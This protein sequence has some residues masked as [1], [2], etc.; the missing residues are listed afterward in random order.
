MSLNCGISAGLGVDC[1]DL[2]KPGGVAKRLWLFNIDDLRVRL[3]TS[4]ASYITDLEFTGYRGLYE[5][6]SAKFSHEANWSEV[7]GEGGN[8]LFQHSVIIRAFNN[9]P[10]DDALIQDLTVADVGA[11]VETNNGELLIFGGGTGLSANEA[12]GSTG[13]QIADNTA[14]QITLVGSEKYLPKRFLRTNFQTSIAYL[15]ALVV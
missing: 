3:D 7:K 2:R 13:R 9:D 15:T 12:T 4:L 10:T 1:S 8:V 5:I 14:T 6:E 11:I